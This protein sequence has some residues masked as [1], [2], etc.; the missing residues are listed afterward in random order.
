MKD[1]Y[2]N[3]YVSTVNGVYVARCELNAN[4]DYALRNAEALEGL[5]DM[6]GIIAREG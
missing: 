4:R 5:V 1:V 3:A 6:P 2:P